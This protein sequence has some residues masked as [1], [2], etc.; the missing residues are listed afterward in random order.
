MNIFSLY[1][2]K[3]YILSVLVSFLITL[4]FLGIVSLVFSFFPP[5]SWLLNAFC[6][7][8]IFLTAL[9]SAFFSAR[10]SSG[11]GM[12]TGIIASLICLLATALIGFLI[13]KS[14]NFPNLFFRNLPIGVL[15]GGA[16][17]ILGINSK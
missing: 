16:G 12:M 1:S 13:F 11:Q 8:S 9:L 6:R 4:V 15:C 7:Y 17:G 10:A 14:G 3:K 2:L 5:A